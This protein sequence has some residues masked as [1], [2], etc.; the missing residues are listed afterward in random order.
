M[1]NIK[2]YMKKYDNLITVLSSIAGQD[3]DT[4]IL[5]WI[6]YTGGLSCVQIVLCV[7]LFKFSF[8]FSNGS[9]TRHA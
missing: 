1:D 5:S 9:K 6:L 7:L 2:L 8:K 3:N 4:A